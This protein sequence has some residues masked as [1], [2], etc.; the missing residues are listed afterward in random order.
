MR[1]RRR[2]NFVS[3]RWDNF[4]QIFS[5]DF[6][7]DS[8]LISKQ[9]WNARWMEMESMVPYRGKNYI[10]VNQVIDFRANEVEKQVS[11]SIC[12]IVHI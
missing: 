5:E 7:I 4:G 9:S 2:D 10:P 1:H 11:E 12:L 8:F 6:Y 3:V